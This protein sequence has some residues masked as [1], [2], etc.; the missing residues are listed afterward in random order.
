M[1]YPKQSTNQ[2]L[3]TIPEAIHEP[4]PTNPKPPTLTPP[5]KPHTPHP[6]PHTVTLNPELTLNPK[7]LTTRQEGVTVH[8]HGLA[9]VGF[10]DSDDKVRRR[11]EALESRP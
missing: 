11:C 7:P 1:V 2:I 6:T 3:Q 8:V 9:V 4:N 10:E 5:Y